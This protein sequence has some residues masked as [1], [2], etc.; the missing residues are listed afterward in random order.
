[1]SIEDMMLTNRTKQV[2]AEL[3][4]L[5]ATG[6]KLISQI[7][8]TGGRLFPNHFK[9]VQTGSSLTIKFYGVELLTRVEM[10]IRDD[11]GAKVLTYLVEQTNPRV[12]KKIDIDLVYDELGN[13][14][15]LMTIDDAARNFVPMLVKELE[16]KKISLLA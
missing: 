15:R 9:A 4:T 3:D 14:N 12:L 6:D 11:D 16:V 2:L 10:R 13:V 8:T 5:K 7:A 1:M